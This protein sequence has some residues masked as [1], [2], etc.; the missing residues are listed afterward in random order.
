MLFGTVEKFN[1]KSIYLV[2]KSHLPQRY[3]KLQTCGHAWAT[4]NY[5]CCSIVDKKSFAFFKSLVEV[6]VVLE[7][8]LNIISLTT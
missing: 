4:W 1:F 3:G 7:F 5:R 6:S 2:G 8:D